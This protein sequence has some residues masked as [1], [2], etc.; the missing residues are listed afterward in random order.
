MEL[1]LMTLWSLQLVKHAAVR[2][3]TFVSGRE[4]MSYV[5]CQLHREIN[6]TSRYMPMLCIVNDDTLLVNYNFS[7]G[8][9]PGPVK[10]NSG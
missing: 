7:G 9:S 6:F 3:L 5:L 8:H 4:C 10:G 1:S 2:L